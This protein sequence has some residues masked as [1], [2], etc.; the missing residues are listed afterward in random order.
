MY[1]PH[2]RY[3]YLYFVY[4]TCVLLITTIYITCHI[5]RYYKKVFIIVFN[6][7]IEF[8]ICVL[9][10][11]YHKKHNIYESNTGTIL[12]IYI[13]CRMHSI[14]TSILS[15]YWHIIVTTFTVFEIDTFQPIHNSEFFHQQ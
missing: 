8:I 14:M 6:P 7:C 4:I 9:I 15:P 3:N 12:C 1:L 2:Y 5:D 10:N 13:I 11:Y